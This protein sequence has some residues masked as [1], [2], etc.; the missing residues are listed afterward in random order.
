M[1]GSLALQQWQ[2]AAAQAFDEI[3]AAH[4]AVGG[5]HPGRR[6]ATQQIN[7]AYVTL[8]SA[9]FQGFARSLHSQVADVIA[10]GSLNPNYSV[11]IQENLTRSRDL[12]RHNP[13][14]NALANDF[15]RFGIDVWT[16]LTALDR[17]TVGRR[18]KLVQLVE[19]R[20]AIAHHDYEQK[21]AAGKLSRTNV[22][23]GACTDWRS[24]LNQ[25]AKGLDQVSAEQ[26][27]AL[28]LPRPW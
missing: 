4:R 26:C 15:G 20:N 13:Q 16:E 12:D 23:L 14:P 3:E 18:A 28:G 7:F 9:R 6:Y 25:L 2:T 11:L 8:L 22:D 27:E 10:A 17:R 21:L 19:W 24:V 5:R 1:A